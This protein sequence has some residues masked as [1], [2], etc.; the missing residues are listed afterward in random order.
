MHALLEPVVGAS[1]TGT[2]LLHMALYV[3]AIQVQNI[4]STIHDGSTCCTQS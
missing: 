2:I 4:S 3:V 1:G